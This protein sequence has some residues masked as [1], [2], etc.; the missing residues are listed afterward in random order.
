MDM[1]VALLTQVSGGEEMVRYCAGEWPQVGDLKGASV[2]LR[3]TFCGRLLAGEID[4][5]I[6]DVAAEPGV[7]DLGLARQF[8]V[9]SYI[10]VP[11]RDVRDRLYVL[12]CMARRAHHELGPSDVRVLEGFV[13]SFVNQLE[14]PDRSSDGL[15]G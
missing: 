7:R 12:C 3:D 10:G 6:P 13:Q 1:E 14:R 4:N 5:A 2:Q 15:R 8:G 11:I 9:G